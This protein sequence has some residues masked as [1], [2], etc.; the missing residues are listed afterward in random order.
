MIDMFECQE[1]HL[2][3]GK[4][5]CC[6]NAEVTLLPDVPHDIEQPATAF[7]LKIFVDLEDDAIPPLING[8]AGR[9]RILVSPVQEETKP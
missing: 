4:L 9:L 7:S 5:H 3:I 8:V 6:E 1:G 2:M